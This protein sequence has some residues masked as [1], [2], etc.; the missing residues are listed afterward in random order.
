MTV[1]RY[2]KTW[3]GLLTAVFDAYAR[4]TFPDSLLGPD[5]PEPMFT[6]ETYT[7]AT[8]PGRADRV[9][10]GLAQKLDRGV[11]NMLMH[12]WLSEEDGCDRLLMRYMRKVFDSPHSIVTNFSDP[13]VLDIHKTALKVSREAEHVRQFVRFQKASD[14]SYFAPIAPKYNAL[15]LAIEYFTDRFADQRW[16]IYDTRRRYGYYYDLH[17]A[18]EVT[19]EDDAHLLE[20]KLGDEIIAQDERLFQCMWRGYHKALTIK[21]RINPKLQRQHMPQRFWKHLTEKQ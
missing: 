6:D 21:E 4:R 13:D 15:P 5:E 12:V 17:K 16:L 7:V 9:W 18:V 10:R 11:R 20:G 19:L 1:F 3:E 14:G 2:D 8:D